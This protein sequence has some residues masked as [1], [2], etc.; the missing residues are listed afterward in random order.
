MV[1]IFVDWT[2]DSRLADPDWAATW[3]NQLCIYHHRSATIISHCCCFSE[4]IKTLNDIFRPPRLNFC[5]NC[6]ANVLV[7]ILQYENS[8]QIEQ[9]KDRLK[10]SWGCIWCIDQASATLVYRLTKRPM[11]HL[12]TN[13][14]KGEKFGLWRISLRYILEK[15]EL[16]SRFKLSMMHAL[17]EQVQPWFSTETFY[18]SIL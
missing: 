9:M 11:P 2:N 3:N 4:Q 17:I 13:N 12:Q 7:W 16:E 1:E 10:I 6:T 14:K 5:R 18:C 8:F 15:G